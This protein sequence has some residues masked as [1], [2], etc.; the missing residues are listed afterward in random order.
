MPISSSVRWV[1]Y[2][3]TDMICLRDV[4]RVWHIL[5]HDSFRAMKNCRILAARLTSR[6][7]IDRVVIE[8]AVSEVTEWINSRLASVSHSDLVETASKWRLFY[9]KQTLLEACWWKRVDIGL[10]SGV[11]LFGKSGSALNAT[12]WKVSRTSNTLWDISCK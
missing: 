7:S 8:P 1:W 11:G 10:V 9:Q 3:S 4:Y 12:F 5:F 2:M 6:F